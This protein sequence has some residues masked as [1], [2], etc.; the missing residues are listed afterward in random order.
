[1]SWISTKSTVKGRGRGRPRYTGLGYGAW[2]AEF[3]DC[4]FV[5]SGLAGRILGYKH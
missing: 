1:M 3:G 5:M 4:I 2:I